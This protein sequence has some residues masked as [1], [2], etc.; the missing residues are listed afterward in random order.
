MQIHPELAAVLEH[1][2][3]APAMDFVAMPVPEIRKVMDQMAFPPAD[4]P[5]HEVRE[6]TMQGGDGQPMKARLYRP[7]DVPTAPAMVFF[8]GG[9]WCIGTID[10]HDNLCRHLAQLTGKNV[11]SVDYRLA[12]EHVFP[13]AL[14]DAYAATRWVAEHAAQLGCDAQAL[15]VAGD[16]A[17]GN[18]AIGVCLRAKE[19]GWKGI[20]QQ[21]L[22]YP[23]C[24]ARMDT[25]SYAMFGQIPML[26]SEAMAAMWR[27]Y[28]PSRAVDALVSVSEY[29]DLTDLPPAVVVTA[30][31]DILRDEG[32]AFAARLQQAGVP[33]QVQRAQGMIHGFASF[34]TMVPVVAQYVQQ[35]CG[36]LQMVAR[37]S[38]SDA[39]I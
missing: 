2:K 18:L 13:A 35:A 26:T 31:L 37:N 19:D 17:G 38:A 28:H 3:D 16:S 39:L 12:P 27:H 21:L 30:E 5:M 10:T 34:S 14:N 32:E 8:H 24:D 7:Q 36:A 23:V 22:I 29:P 15:T 6:L 33:V 1:F 25:E 9:G 4:L 20:A 11:V